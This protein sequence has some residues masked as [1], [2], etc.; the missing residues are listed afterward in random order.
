MRKNR[1]IK[2]AVMTVAMVMAIV[3]ILALP[4]LIDWFYGMGKLEKIY[5]NAFSAETWF[6]FAGSYFPAVIMGI[7]AL[8]QTYIIRY[9]DKKYEELEKRYRYVPA[10]HAFVYRYIDDGQTIG[11]YSIEEIER[12][13]GVDIIQN[14]A[15]EWEK[16]YIIECNIYSKDGIDI[17]SAIVKKIEW[18]INGCVY[19]QK[20]AVQMAS[21]VKRVSCSKQK[22][23]VFWCF[24]GSKQ[25]AE[26]V[27]QCML[28]GYRRDL[29]FEN[30]VLTIDLQISDKIKKNCTLEMRFRMQPTKDNYKMIS[31]EE[32]YIV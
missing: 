28:S 13:F 1:R 25:I 2:N 8:C 27:A 29:R 23:Y 21:M 31:V 30:S 32:Y 7:L 19:C 17:N 20:N 9:Q 18:T 14:P 11:C 12:M 22:V 4:F 10:G 5:D 24:D 16:G 6:S 26:E 3:V 15:N